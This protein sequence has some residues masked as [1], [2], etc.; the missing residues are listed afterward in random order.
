MVEWLSEKIMNYNEIN[1]WPHGYLVQNFDTVSAACEL[2]I[3]LGAV[4]M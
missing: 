4:I 1:L 3:Q 2:V